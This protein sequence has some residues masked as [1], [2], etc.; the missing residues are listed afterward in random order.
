MLFDFADSI[1]HLRQNGV[2]AH[3]TMGGHFPTVEPKVTLEVIPGL[4]SVIRCEGEQTLLELYYHLN[5]PDS[6]DQIKGLA[7]R[8][9]GI[10]KV[11]PPRPLIRNLD[12]LPFPVR[13]NVTST[14]RG[15]GSCSI[16]SGRGCNSNCSFC[17][18]RQFY[19]ESPGPRR[20]SRSPSNVVKEM[21]ELYKE[22]DI[23]I[24]T[25]L[26]DD[27][28][29]IGHS[30]EQWINDF[31]QELEQE[32]IAD[33]IMW[34]ISCRVDEIDVE[35]IN[36][37]IKVGLKCIQVGIESGNNQALK[38]YNKRYT[39]DDVHKTLNL[40]QDLEM[41]F[42]FGFMI[43]NPDST[44]AAVKEDIAFLKE[45]RRNSDA[46]ICFT[47]M[48]PYSGTPIANRLKKEG[49]LKGTIASPDYEFRDEK[50]ELLQLFIVQAFYHRNFD[51]D[52]LVVRLRNA[53]LSAW[54][55][56]KFYSNKYDAQS[57]TKAIRDVIR[58]CNDTCLE[59]L[60]LAVSFIDQMSREDIL[61]NWHFLEQL[62]KREKEL[63]MQL[64]SYLNFLINYHS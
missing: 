38:T 60:S 40:L 14:R 37:L 62:T 54:V 39:V 50:L 22:R 26:D 17:S 12:S 31:I 36:K 7:Y 35:L 20:R 1:F 27:F 53:R 8:R 55:Q 48:T 52:G 6:W 61:D 24:F 23:R 9:D 19:K 21:V 43:L 47:K 57:Y 15:V 4:N 64:T 29:M 16:I 44:L 45:I 11:N 3:F 46:I 5:Q 2:K 10:I 34:C 13:S 25:F 30:Q 32:K 51:R 28:P 56:E 59:N 33:Q 49:R 41:P 18:I 58:K 42:D 63:E